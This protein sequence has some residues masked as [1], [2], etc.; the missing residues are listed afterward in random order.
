MNS[1]RA[2]RLALPRANAI[3][4]AAASQNVAPM[5]AALVVVLPRAA[6]SPSRSFHTTPA[7]LKKSKAKKM[8]EQQENNP[9]SS[10]SSSSSS[11]HSA[12]TSTS[13]HDDDADAARH[14]KPDAA[15]PLNT[16]DLTSRWAALDTHFRDALRRLATGGR[17]NPDSI[18]ALPV[19]PD[20]KS[21]ERFPLRELAQ[22]VPKGGRTVALLAHDRAHLKPISDA[23]QASPDFNQ[24][25]QP[26]PDNDLELLLKV[27][28]ERKE[29]LVVKA[30]ALTLAWRERVRHASDRR[31]K[32]VAKWA[33][34]K[35]IGPDLRKR[36][37]AEAQKQQNKVMDGIDQVEKQTLQRFK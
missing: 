23:V 16:D 27:E 26:S 22:V 12:S 35:E 6:S 8:V 5:S 7:A 25:P 18:G 4:R 14:P 30:K 13:D 34:Q 17:F 21:P 11:R 19:A 15:D 9:S 37:D 24:Q 36:V 28:P 10:P 32:V 31:K 2:H 20:P 1:F 3:I 29:D 33:M